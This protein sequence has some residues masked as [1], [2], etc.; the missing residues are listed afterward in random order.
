MIF[1]LLFYWS[2]NVNLIYVDGGE[3]RLLTHGKRLVFE[4]RFKTPVRQ[5]ALA[6]QSIFHAKG[7][8]KVHEGH[9]KAGLARGRQ[10]SG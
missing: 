4:I 3:N 2:R 10:W 7:S 8:R 9:A 1:A 5:A 6:R